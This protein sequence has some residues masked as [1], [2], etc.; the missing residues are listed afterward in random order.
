MKFSESH[1]GIPEVYGDEGIGS[2]HVPKPRVDGMKERSANF[3]VDINIA[4]V[5][6]GGGRYGKAKSIA[7]WEPHNGSVQR[8]TS[9]HAGGQCCGEYYGEY[10]EI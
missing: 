1:D 5:G 4:N 7:L 8:K 2:V 10:G 6:E 3:V 9:Q